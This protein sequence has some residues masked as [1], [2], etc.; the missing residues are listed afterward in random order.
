MEQKSLVL[1]VEDEKGIRNFISTVLEVNGYRALEAKNGKEAL[2]LFTSR[3]PDL[4]LLDLGLPDMD[5][6]EVLE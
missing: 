6:T 1:L 4:I 3:C 5:G 2:E